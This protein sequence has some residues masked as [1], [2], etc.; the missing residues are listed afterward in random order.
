MK[1]EIKCPYYGIDIHGFELWCDNWIGGSSFITRGE[2]KEVV[3]PTIK[4]C[5][6]EVK[7]IK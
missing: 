2:E 5:I 3:F 6:T 1:A 4:E 7:I